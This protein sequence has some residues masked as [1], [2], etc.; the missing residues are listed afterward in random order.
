MAASEKELRTL[1]FLNE[2]FGQGYVKLEDFN[3][4][5]E[6]FLDKRQIRR[7]L[8]D[9]SLEFPIESKTGGNGGYKLS[10]KIQ[11]ILPYCDTAMILTTINEIKDS[12]KSI[13]Y[14]IDLSRNIKTKYLYGSSTI[15]GDNVF[16]IIKISKCIE[17]RRKINFNFQLK[18]V[19]EEKD[20]E[21]YFV[22]F[23]HGEYFLRAKHEGEMKSY[24]LN[25][26][27]NI[28]ATKK[29]FD[30]DEEL[31][32]KEKELA[33]NSYGSGSASKKNKLV[34]QIINPL[35]NIRGVFDEKGELKDD[36]FIVEYYDEDD[37]LSKV[38]SLRTKVKIIEPETLIQK[39]NMEVEI[40]RLIN[41]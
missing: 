33:L 36:K 17:N 40:M 9:L 21:P 11:S 28:I 16:K 10:S 38:L 7:Y 39:Y 41:R 12:S 29:L 13:R 30:Y 14:A 27:S 1:Y 35:E 24:S 37:V 34:L 4:F 5:C 15:A 22:Y 3:Y 18:F 2:R 32:N 26:V 19:Y 25:D 20:V 6:L 31:K 8:D 23:T